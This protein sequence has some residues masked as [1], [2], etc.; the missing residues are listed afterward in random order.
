M[1][2]LLFILLLPIL[3][4]AD[5]TQKGV[6]GLPSIDTLPTWEWDIKS[7]RTDYL[8]GLSLG[9]LLPGG[10]QYYT[11]HYVRAG[12]LTAF[13]TYLLSEVLYNQPLRRSKR[14]S[15]A[16]QDLRDAMPYADSM[17]LFPSSKR[18]DS[19]S[20]SF[21]NQLDNARENLNVIEENNGLLISE[22]AWLA[23][24]H[25]YGL[26]DGYEMIHRNRN[27]RSTETKSVTTAVLLSALLPGSGQIYNGSYGKAGLLYMSF[28]GSYYSFQA[29]QHT[30]DYYD[31]RRRI[32]FAEN[33]SSLYSEMSDRATF[34]RKKRNQYFWAPLLFYFYSIADAA[35]DAKLSDFDDPKNFAWAPIGPDLSPGISLA[36]NF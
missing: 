14:L 12:F 29:R 15:S 4:L 8:T 25:L 35:V 1:P 21:H 11:K 33:N 10:A 23:G 20:Q 17:T 18:Y 36:F 30:V 34:F 16:D 2:F 13:E 22:W 7:E 31:Q 26:M 32:A 27:P 5:P 6:S 28:I 24:L 3:G 19:W 9:L